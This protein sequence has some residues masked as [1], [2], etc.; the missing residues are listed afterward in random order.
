MAEDPQIDARHAMIRRAERFSNL[1]RGTQF[2]AMP[3]TVIE[4][5]R[6]ALE[7]SAPGVSE[8]G[9]GIQSSAE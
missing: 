1:A 6:V 9:G 5:E 3:L 4:R 2:D 7:S 8:A